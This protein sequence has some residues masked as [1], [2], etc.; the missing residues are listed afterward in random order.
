MHS[1]VVCLCD[2]KPDVFYPVLDD[3][4]LNLC[5]FQFYLLSDSG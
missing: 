5:C 2:G 1:D 3:E 4:P